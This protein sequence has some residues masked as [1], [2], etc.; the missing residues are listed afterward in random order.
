M[1]LRVPS[2]WFFSLTG[3]IMIGWG[4]YAPDDRAALTTGNVNLYTG[5]CLLIF[6]AFLLLLAWRATRLEKGSNP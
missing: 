6:G 3:L 5:I 1:D 4:L 2:G